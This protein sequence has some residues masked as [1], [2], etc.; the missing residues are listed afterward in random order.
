MRGLCHWKSNTSLLK[1]LNF[2]VSNIKLLLNTLEKSCSCQ[3]LL[4]IIF[5]VFDNYLKKPCTSQESNL[6]YHQAHLMFFCVGA[7]MFCFFSKDGERCLFFCI[8]YL[9]ASQLKKYGKMQS[10]LSSFSPSR[11]HKFFLLP[12]G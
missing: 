11:A 8:F 2:E 4:L 1:Q 10:F 6:P 7:C 9:L 3:T 5:T 12:R